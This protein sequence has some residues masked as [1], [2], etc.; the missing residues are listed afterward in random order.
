MKDEVAL[1]LGDG[2]R[3]SPATRSASACSP[4]KHVDIGPLGRD[5]RLRTAAPRP[6]PGRGP[7]CLVQPRLAGEVG[8]DEPALPLELGRGV[9]HR[10]GRVDATPGLRDAGASRLDL[11]PMRAIRSP[12]VASFCAACSASR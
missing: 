7:R 4:C 2:G 6:A 12:G 9:W 1:G 10:L 3:S 5:G 11:A 8:A